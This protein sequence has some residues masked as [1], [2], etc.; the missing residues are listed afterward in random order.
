M[1]W[2]KSQVNN[3]QYVNLCPQ[4]VSSGG[5]RAQF[6]SAVHEAREVDLLVPRARGKRAVLAPEQEQRGTSSAMSGH[7]PGTRGSSCS[8]KRRKGE[9]PKAPSVNGDGVVGEGRGC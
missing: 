8:W 1:D 9:H 2:T 4:G 7:V 5:C 6:W 3:Y